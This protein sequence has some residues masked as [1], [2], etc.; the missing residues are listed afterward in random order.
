MSPPQCTGPEQTWAPPRWEAG[1]AGLTRPAEREPEVGL[2]SPR[3]HRPP[4]D[5]VLW[6]P[7]MSQVWNGGKQPSG[8]KTQT[9]Q[10]RQPTKPPDPA[11]DSQE[12]GRTAELHPETQRYT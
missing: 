6:G 9:T 12:G 7:A 8:G 1:E 10:P 3:P 11:N 2:A 5:V 4:T